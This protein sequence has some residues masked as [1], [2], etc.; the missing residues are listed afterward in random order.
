MANKK[1]TIN[2]NTVWVDDETNKIS[3]Y[4]PSVTN[5]GK[6]AEKVPAGVPSNTPLGNMLSHQATENAERDVLEQAT[7]DPG[8]HEQQKK[9][10]DERR[11]KLTNVRDG[12]Y[13]PKQEI[14]RYG[15][16]TYD[17]MTKGLQ[18]AAIVKP[19]KEWAA[20]LNTEETE[21]QKQADV[22][23][24][25]AREESKELSDEIHTAEKDALRE[26]ES[27]EIAEMQKKDEIDLAPPPPASAS[28]PTSEPAT[29]VKSEP[30]SESKPAEDEDDDDW[31]RKYIDSY[32]QPKNA[33]EYLKDLWNSGKA[34]KAAAVGNVL[35]NLLGAAGSGLAGKEYNSSWNKYKDNYIKEM[36]ERENRAY[37]D[38]QDFVKTAKTNEQSRNEMAKMIDFM[39]REG[40]EISP[41]DAVKIKNYMNNTQKSSLLDTLLTELVVK[42]KD[43]GFF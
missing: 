22:E 9:E 35:G 37:N 3:H 38:A 21:E 2:G 29:P 18:D 17:K 8:L 26:G 31:A 24:Q 33:A 27:P 34:G 36:A 20:P 30:K 13:T 32:K 19:V 28:E 14:E 4:E 5:S 16:E 39:A 11:E 23:N 40:G 25:E 6:N 12:V 7:K 15:N 42:A 41:E 1:K 43:K 10:A